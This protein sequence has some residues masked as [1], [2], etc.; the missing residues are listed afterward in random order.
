M[1]P[2]NE[3]DPIKDPQT[4]GSETRAQVDDEN[5][6]ILQ[7]DVTP[8]MISRAKDQ[9][10]KQAKKAEEAV[11][12]KVSAKRRMQQ[13]GRIFDF[14]NDSLVI[15]T[16]D[17]DIN[18][19]SAVEGS[20]NVKIVE[21]KKFGYDPVEKNLVV[22]Q[23]MVDNAG[24]P[25]LVMRELIRATA[26]EDTDNGKLI[27]KDREAQRK[28][29]KDRELH[30]H[31]YKWWSGHE[32]QKQYEKAE[33]AASK[34]RVAAEKALDEEVEKHL[35]AFKQK[36]GF[37]LRGLEDTEKVKQEIKDRLKAEQSELVFPIDEDGKGYLTG[38][39]E[40]RYEAWK[41]NNEVF[42][43]ARFRT[44]INKTRINSKW[45]GRL[46]GG[47]IF[48]AGIAS[49]ALKPVRN[50]M[51]NRLHNLQHKAWRSAKANFFGAPGE[52][53]GLAKDLMD[54][55]GDWSTG[56]RKTNLFD[57]FGIRNGAEKWS[58]HFK[59]KRDQI[60]KE[61]IPKPSWEEEEEA[62]KKFAKTA[63]KKKKGKA[64]EGKNKGGGELK[65]AD[66]GDEKAA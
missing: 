62:I 65:V 23:D 45:G 51:R 36:E 49:T 35:D 17:K 44:K 53:L 37:D 19:R 52:L 56:S 31:T 41:G 26:T 43:D 39:K 55:F 29:A 20:E 7:Q 47:G 12:V 21:G 16:G 57:T 30:E 5:K 9:V 10:V 27:A 2:L 6:P 24:A 25:V 54:V 15:E 11:A 18:L 33:R 63:S 38:E 22:P 60:K 46:Y 1:D 34:Q 3:R 66:K 32:N 48:A 64:Q 28:L 59:G 13:R 50:F 58:K 42:Q 4:S 8:E 61:K 40:S 14:E